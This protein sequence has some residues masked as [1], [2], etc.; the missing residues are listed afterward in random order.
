MTITGRQAEAAE[1][2]QILWQATLFTAGHSIHME[3]I[4]VFSLL[5]VSLTYYYL[6]T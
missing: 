1:Q 2:L 6:M 5:M 3:L 4:V